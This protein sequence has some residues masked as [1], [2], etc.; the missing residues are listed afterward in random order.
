MPE[1][2]INILSPSQLTLTAPSSEGALGCGVGR[3]V[4]APTVVNW[5]CGGEGRETRPLQ[6]RGAVTGGRL[7]PLHSTLN[8]CR[9]AICRPWAEEDGAIL[10]F[11]F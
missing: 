1:G 2:E 9:A 5:G 11:E 7:P 10:H 3:Q 4:A 8:R 6:G